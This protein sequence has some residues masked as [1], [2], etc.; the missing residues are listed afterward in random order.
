MNPYV[1]ALI[2]YLGVWP[3]TNY[4]SEKF[5]PH[6]NKPLPDLI[7][8]IFSPLRPYL[9]PFSLIKD[10]LAFIPVSYAAIILH[11]YRPDLIDLFVDYICGLFLLRCI[12][13]SVT[14][15][16]TSIEDA[17]LRSFQKKFFVGGC[18]DLIFSG[19]VAHYY[20]SIL[21]LQYSNFLPPSDFLSFWMSSII[22]IVSIILR[23]HYTIDVI[24]VFPVIWCWS[25]YMLK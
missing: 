16:P 9:K 2:V 8:Y 14:I 12:F 15:L 7:Q 6:P 22:G 19:H 23:H 13:F 5:A 24:V 18:H 20:A 1:K 21:F 17:H 10:V 4:L 3:L 25:S 11:L